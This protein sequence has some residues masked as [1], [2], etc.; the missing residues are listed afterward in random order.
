MDKKNILQQAEKNKWIVGKKY[1]V[2]SISSLFKQQLSHQLITGQFIKIKVEQQSK[3]SND[4]LWLE[5]N[6]TGKYAF[7][8]FIN[9]YLREK[10]GQQNLF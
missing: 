2:I 3:L 4:W 9:Q 8:Q 10:K 5:K 6:K 1:E 7:P